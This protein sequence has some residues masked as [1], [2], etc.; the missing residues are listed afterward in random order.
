MTDLL[1]VDVHHAAHGHLHGTTD[2][3]VE[4]PPDRT[5]M[6]GTCPRCGV[7]MKAD[8]TWCQRCYITVRNVATTSDFPTAEDL[9][10]WC[11]FRLL[12]ALQSG[13]RSAVVWP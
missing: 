10:A 4:M 7:P 1:L 11:M 3:A 9:T 2:F 8:A 5:D 6:T 12:K 13:D